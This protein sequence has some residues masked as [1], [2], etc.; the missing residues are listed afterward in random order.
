MVACSEDYKVLYGNVLEV[1]L[2][3]DGECSSTCGAMVPCMHRT[4][5]FQAHR[6]GA[7]S[8][9]AVPILG[10]MLA[11]GPV[12]CFLAIV[13]ERGMP[14]IVGQ[15]DSDLSIGRQFEEFAGLRGSLV[16]TSMVLEP[17]VLLCEVV[18]RVHSK[19][20]VWIILRGIGTTFA[21]H[22]WCPCCCMCR[23]EGS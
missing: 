2:V 15:L 16:A 12:R 9:P 3:A 18:K 23:G 4:I 7:V 21:V 5:L 14:A 1:G 17:P 22:A 19:I 11:I 20:C 13:R 6:R 10:M 8:A